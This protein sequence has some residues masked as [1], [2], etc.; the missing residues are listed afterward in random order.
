MINDSIERRNAPGAA[1]LGVGFEFCNRLGN[2]LDGGVRRDLSM[3]HQPRTRPRVEESAYEA[4]KR[5]RIFGVRG[6]G[7]TR[8][9]DHPIGVE[10]VRRFRRR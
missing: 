7:V 10:F 2:E 3:R 6:S 8:R 5:F 4:G 1:D 9:E